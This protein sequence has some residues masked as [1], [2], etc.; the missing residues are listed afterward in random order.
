ML[1]LENLA[2]FHVVAVIQGPHDFDLF[3][4]AFLPVFLTVGG[5]FGEGFDSKAA[6]VFDSLHQVDRG[7]VALSDLLDGSKLFVEVSLV[8]GHLQEALP[9]LLVVVG[10]LEHHL[11]GGSCEEDAVGGDLEPEVK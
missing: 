5:F 9:L 4:K 8:Q 10:E 6:S 11:L 3:H 1:R 2:Q 7:K